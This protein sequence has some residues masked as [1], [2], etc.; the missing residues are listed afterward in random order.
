M[1]NP[2][3]NPNIRD[4]GFGSKSRTKAQDDEYRSRIKGVPKKRKWTKE[5]CILQ[6]EDIMEILRKKVVADENLKDLEV[7]TNKMMDII[8]YLYPP[9]QQSVNMNVNV[10]TLWEQIQLRLKEQDKEKN[11]TLIIEDGK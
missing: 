7:I 9:V 11:N 5:I 6:L 4:I 8:K 3:G 10:N 2:V 1:A